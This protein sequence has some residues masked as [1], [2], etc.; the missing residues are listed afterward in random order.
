MIKIHLMFYQSWRRY[1]SFIG[2]SGRVSFG[3]VHFLVLGLWKEK[4]NRMFED[5]ASSF[6]SFWLLVRHDVS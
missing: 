6:V 2:G 5:K 3:I 1:S 4:N